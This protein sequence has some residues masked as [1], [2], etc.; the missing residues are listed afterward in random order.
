MTREPDD[1]LMVFAPDLSHADQSIS[2]GTRTLMTF[3]SDGRVTAD[4]TLKPDETAAA[5]IE[6]LT[7]NG[8]LR[9]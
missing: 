3:H 2:S 9:R 5:I 1:T 6:L 8:W 4:P 7:K